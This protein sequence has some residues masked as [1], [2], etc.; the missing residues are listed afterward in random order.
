MYLS[1]ISG[2]LGENKEE[3]WP[4][5]CFFRL[6][7]GARA[8]FV[9][10]VGDV[11]LPGA[12]LLALPGLFFGDFD[13]GGETLATCISTEG[14]GRESTS[15]SFFEFLCAA[16]LG[17]DCDEVFLFDLVGLLCGGC[18]GGDTSTGSFFDLLFTA[19]GGLL[20]GVLLCALELLMIS[21]SEVESLQLSAFM[22]L[23]LP[24][25]TGATAFRLVCFTEKGALTLPLLLLT[26][27]A[28]VLLGLAKVE[29]PAAEGKALA[30]L[31]VRI[32]PDT[33]YLLEFMFMTM[34]SNR[35]P[36]PERN[37]SFLS[38]KVLCSAF[39]FPFM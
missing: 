32:H 2:S 35:V 24:L 34:A 27:A 21:E 9:L 23:D 16:N 14:S 7:L 1:L 25:V 20:G 8:A 31:W 38:F 3:D 5:L 28:L 37:G 22:F 18:T 33:L 36:L 6:R 19:N 10:A 17:L 26:K 4:C 11:L 15:G 13:G 30:F 29:S 12:L 39:A